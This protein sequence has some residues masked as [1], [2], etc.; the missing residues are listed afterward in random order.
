MTM[1]DSSAREPIL[2]FDNVSKTYHAHRHDKLVFNDI[3]FSI[4]RGESIGVVG[5]N[6]AGK[7]TMMRL[8]AGVEAPTAG[9]VKRFGTISWPLGYSS[10][11]SAGL[12]G[13]D[14]TRFIARI[15]GE[16]EDEM[17][18]RVQSF[19]ELGR[20]FWEP[21]D[22]Y[23][24]GMAA[25]LAFGISLTIKFDCY[26]ID[27]IVSVGDERFRRKCEDALMERRVDG[28]LIMISHEP[29]TLRQYC[30]RGAVLYGGSLTF[31]DSVSEACEVHYGLQTV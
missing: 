22:T 8:M 18:D 11:M 6:G 29:G 28:T 27:E 26:L 3:N 7:S 23:S 21:V 15:Y 24:S 12:T 2:V 19:A 25:R 13:A 30:E 31:F 1:T 4:A 17:L 20:Y 16:D 10:A 9:E 5:A 14:N